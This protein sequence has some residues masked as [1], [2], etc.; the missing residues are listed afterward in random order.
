MTFSQTLVKRH[1]FLS[2]LGERQSA[3]IAGKSIIEAFAVLA[4]AIRAFNGWLSKESR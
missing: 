4:N 1:D 3:Q 2:I